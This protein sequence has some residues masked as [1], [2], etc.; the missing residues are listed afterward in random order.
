MIPHPYFY[1][2]LI[3]S[4]HAQIQYDMQKI[5]MQAHVRQRRTLVRFTVGSL[6]TLLVVLGSY[7]QRIGQRNE[8][9]LHSS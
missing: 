8:A 1:E 5:R 2:K 3:A 6:G 7:L 4:H 9:S